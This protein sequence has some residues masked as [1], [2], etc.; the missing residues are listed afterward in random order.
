M[1]HLFSEKVDRG[2][3]YPYK[4]KLSAFATK[5]ESTILASI[6]NV[7]AD[8]P[9]CM[10]TCQWVYVDEPHQEVCTWFRGSTGP[11]FDN[12]N[13]NFMAENEVYLLLL[14]YN[15]NKFRP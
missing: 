11:F 14:K 3:F 7:N 2:M 15:K 5:K 6:Y 9:M 4:I 13:W 1:K 10:Y 8:L 12:K